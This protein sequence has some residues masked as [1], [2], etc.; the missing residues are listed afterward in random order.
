[1]AKINI[2]GVADRT[3]APVCAWIAKQNPGQILIITPTYVGAKRVA[4]DLSFFIDKKIFVVPGDDGMLINYEVK[5]KD[6]LYGKL[7]ILKRVAVGEDCI[8]ICPISEMLKK[9]PPRKFFTERKISV[10][11]GKTI[12]VREIATALVDMGYEREPK[13]YAPGQFSLRGEIMDVFTPYDP[14][15]Y[16]IDFFDM[17]VDSVKTFD[18]ELQRSIAEV[19]GFDIYPATVLPEGYPAYMENFLGSVYEDAVSIQ[20]YFCGSSIIVDDAGRCYE[21][22]TSL[23]EEQEASLKRVIEEGKTEAKEI[24]SIACTGDYLNVY[25]E[26]AKVWILTPFAKVIKGAEE[27]DGIHSLL[28]HSTMSY[29]GKTDLLERDLVNYIDKG[30]EITIACSSEERLNSIKDFL[31]CAGLSSKVKLKEGNLSGGVDFPKEKICYISDADIFGDRR[32]R[33]KRRRVSK[34]GQVIKSFTDI[35]SGDFVVHENHGIG[36]YIGIQ[37]LDVAGVKRDYLKIKYAGDDMLYIPV[38]QMNLIQKYVGANSTS[39]KINKLSGG[40]WRATKAKAKAAVAGMAEELLEV[41]AGRMSESGFAFGSDSVWQKEFEETFAYEETPDQLKCSDEIKA[42]MEKAWPMDRLLCGDVGYGKTEVA[43]RAMFKAAE[44]GKQVAVLVP[45][46]LLANQ[47]Y[48]TLRE[49]FERFPFKVEMLSRY[50]SEREQ[51]DI[52]ERLHTG[53]VDIVIG[54]HRLLSDD[55]SFK[56]LGLLIVDEEQRFGVSHKEKIKKLRANVDVLTLSATPIPRTL[57]MA[58]VGM[59]D[60]SLIEEPPEGRYPVQTYVVEEDDI[61]IR[62]AIERE[63]DRGG[64]VYIIY[65]KITGINRVAERVKRLMPQARIATGHG[66]M[67]ESAME[68]VM[69]SFIDGNIDILIA[70]TI[71]ESGIDIPNVN[72]LIVLDADK[73]GLSQLYQL[74]G[75]V[76]RSNRLAY[77]YLM[78]RKEKVLTEVAEKRLRAIKDFTEFGAGFKIAMRD[79]EIRGAGNILG[80]EQS[81]HL[82]N[83]GYELYCK[84]VDDAV[85]TL[86]GEEVR[87]ARGEMSIDLNVEAYI[88]D[89]Y[90]EDQLTK[91]EMYKKIADLQSEDEASEVR[92]ELVDR[93]GPVPGETEN[94]I[95]IALIRNLGE[96][97]SIK[98]LMRKA[99][100]LV[101]D[102]GRVGEKPVP[103]TIKDKSNVLEECKEL[104]ALLKAGENMRQNS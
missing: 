49:R 13:A 100:K 68:D 17:D 69:Q 103:V 1:M 97:L 77:A 93:F 65:N 91:L 29:N 61:I 23:C 94:L 84:M 22:A 96:E 15:P 7:G 36:K 75:R 85:K 33:A 86:K 39:P 37:Q 66:R 27:L 43:A 28:S 98:K 38:D 55:V 80:A 59:R 95:Q 82:I 45:T 56:D 20:D 18:P 50:K 62:D 21:T 58:L 60:M 88:A 63:L 47:H 11:A 64:Q 41:I 25:R 46:T 8:V 6:S 44:A 42:D 30:Y 83:V 72:T 70:T 24:R 40:E 34:E 32:S 5:N 31:S 67:N 57:N 73:Y 102:Y 71:V 53:K 26:D 14:L 92:E 81:G 51:R 9:L 87:L 48:H 12:D 19:K 16:R 35:N 74:R 104:L 79:L 10:S 2:S 3:T 99:N 54:T 78:H 89:R 90:I 4:K 52:C 76:G 101:L